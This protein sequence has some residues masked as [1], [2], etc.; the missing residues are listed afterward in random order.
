[1]GSFVATQSDLGLWPRL[2]LTR[3]FS[4]I[5]VTYGY[6]SLTNLLLA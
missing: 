2:P 5:L 1:M 6:E 3:L 4:L